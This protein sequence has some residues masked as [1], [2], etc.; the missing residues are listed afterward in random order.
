MIKRLVQII[1]KYSGCNHEEK[2]NSYYENIT[3]DGDEWALEDDS[4]KGS[5]VGGENN[6]LPEKKFPVEN[7]SGKGQVQDE[8]KESWEKD[9][10]DTPSGS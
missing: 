6:E 4:E 5:L 3:D 9:E 8:V 2:L 7:N 10:K 1:R